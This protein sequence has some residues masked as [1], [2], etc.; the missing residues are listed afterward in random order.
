[1]VFVVEIQPPDMLPFLDQQRTQ[2]LIDTGVPQY[3][4]KNAETVHSSVSISGGLQNCM[5][6]GH[7]IALSN[8]R[9]SSGTD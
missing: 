6:T 8:Q 5:L 7:Q 3:R 1:M 2:R 4:H 9:Q